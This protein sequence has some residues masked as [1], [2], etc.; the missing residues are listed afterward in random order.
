MPRLKRLPPISFG[1]YYIA[2]QAERGRNLVTSGADV[3]MFLEVMRVTLHKKGAA[4][5][6]GDV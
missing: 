1:T 3:K 4:L 2:L 6:A 5:H